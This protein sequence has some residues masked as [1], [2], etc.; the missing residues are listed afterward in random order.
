MFTQ[1]DI[2]KLATYSFFEELDNI[3]EHSGVSPNTLSA[4]HIGSILKEAGIGNVIQKGLGA[5]KGFGTNAASSLQRGAGAIKST[6]S[7]TLGN[8][9][10]RIS[11]GFQKAKDFAGNEIG[12]LNQ[13][14]GNRMAN[15][16]GI[17]FNKFMP[18]DAAKGVAS[19]VAGAKDYAA[20]AIKRYAPGVVDKYEQLKSKLPSY[21]HTPVKGADTASTQVGGAINTVATSPIAKGVQSYFNNSNP[22]V[23]HVAGRI[24]G[25]T[26]QHIGNFAGKLMNRFGGAAAPI[27]KAASIEGTNTMLHEDFEKVATLAF[28]E[29]LLEIEKAASE[30][31]TAD[32]DLLESIVKEALNLGGALQKVRG[33]IANV[34]G[35]I[36]PTLN[37][38]VMQAAQE[39]AAKMQGSK[40]VFV[41]GMGET[42]AHKAHSPMRLGFAA[43]NP[44]GTAAETLASGA[45]HAASQGL[46]NIGG[47]IQ[48]AHGA[49]DEATRIGRS[50]TPAGRI[51]SAVGEMGGK[52]QGTFSPGGGGHNILTKK[53]PLAAEIGGAVGAGT[54]L[55]APVG[56][57]GALGKLGLGALGK[58]VP[59]VGHAL[60]HAP[61]AMDALAHKA[62][63]GLKGIGHAVEHTG[64]D[65]LGTKGQA[66]MQGGGNIAHQAGHQMAHA[67]H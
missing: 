11:S 53:L 27:Q 17:K 1:E 54:L 56:A 24:A 16:T 50:M 38:P 61:H 45:G 35:K 62:G 42:L 26:A 19:G 32:V 20:G 25:D 40:N 49:M 39:R 29:E 48:K 37:K 23:G 10:A 5:I 41:R 36:S 4:D 44:V 67:A 59:V 65:L 9:G 8:A 7:N 18:Q 64:A 15:D 60:E 28:F 58:A 14:I 66:L 63:I 51:R 22:I 55:H 30:V 57:A 21:L 34:A 3:A 13:A 47:K 46:S 31:Y 12:H 6:L 2:I 33:G 43:A 52:M